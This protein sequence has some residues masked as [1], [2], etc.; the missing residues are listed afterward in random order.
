MTE[1]KITGQMLKDIIEKVYNKKLDIV[2]V[3]L[4]NDSEI[5]KDLSKFNII[6][7]DGI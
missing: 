7:E 4:N 3:E 2:L 1:I 5:V 6:M